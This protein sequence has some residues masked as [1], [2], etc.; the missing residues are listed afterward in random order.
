MN[1]EYLQ[2]KLDNHFI[3]SSVLLGKCK[4]IDSTSQEAPAFSD[5]RYFPFYYYLGTQVSPK[6]VLQIGAKLGLIG[7]CFNQG[8]KTVEKWLAMDAYEG[9]P[10]ANIIESNLKMFGKAKVGFMLLNNSLLDMN[11]NLDY[12]IDLGLLTE[13]YDKEK[14]RKYMEF[15]WRHLKPEGL[16]VVDYIHDDTVR[17]SFDDFSRVKNREPVV[18]NTR[19]GVGIVTR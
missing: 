19:Y 5:P 8:C 13:K 12:S 14:T 7:A 2:S 6:S 18:F 9:R 4:L 11:S 16:L 10:P 15:L 1:A 17:S 3:S